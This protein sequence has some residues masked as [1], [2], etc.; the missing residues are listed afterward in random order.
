M[1]K[2]TSAV[3][4]SL[5]DTYT[6][7]IPAAWDVTFIPREY[8]A[9]SLAAACAGASF[10]WLYS[11]QPLTAPMLQSLTTVKNV[12]LLGAG[13]DRVDLAAARAMHITVSNNRGVNGDEVAEWAVG[14][15]I[16][17]LRDYARFDRERRTDGYRAAARRH[18]AGTHHAL[19]AS[20]IGLVGMGSI[21]RGVAERLAGWGCEIYY[22][23]RH[24]LPPDAEAA[25]GVRYLPFDELLSSCD[26][27]SLHTPLT[28]ETRHMIAAPQLALMKPTAYLV[29][30][31]RGELIDDEALATALENG[32]LLGAALDVLSPE[33]PEADHPLLNLS[34]AAAARLTLS[35]HVGGTTAESYRKMLSG[36]IAQTK[37][38][39]AGQPLPN[40]LN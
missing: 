5:F 33:P 32:K 2:I 8:T 29:N 31:A 7:T 14:M 22:H 40:A 20:K 25:T 9:E 26:V 37:L 28:P 4:K 35:P 15:M 16:T 12:M 39:I 6:V 1:V 13:F 34:P 23:S 24:R 19:H 18:A 36:F 21:G 10:L 3:P 30:T 11:I 38:V 27:I 17:G